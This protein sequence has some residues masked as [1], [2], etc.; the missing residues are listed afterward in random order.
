MKRFY[1]WVLICAPLCLF[2]WSADLSQTEQLIHD[3]KYLEAIEALDTAQNEQ[4]YQSLAIY[5]N[6]GYCYFK[7][8][9]RA[10][11]VL[12]YERALRLS[13]R[14]K[15]LKEVLKTLND[16]LENQIFEIPEFVL[17]RVY[18]SVVTLFNSSVWAFL[19]LFLLGLIVILVAVVLFKFRFRKYLYIISSL[20]LLML[21]T[22]LMS[23]HKKYLESN[24]DY[25][26]VMKNDISLMT[27]ADERSGGIAL[28][29]AGTKVNVIDEIA[30]WYKVMLSD[31]SVG[32]LKKEELEII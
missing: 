18:N 12:N 16:Q 28:L 30:E 17:V 25:A 1:L 8:D 29:S 5:S 6:L 27:A 10:N 13:P 22:S 11:A 32:W 3:G 20:V 19:Q 4:K 31:K 9:D 15:G 14:D 21:V 26:I 2:S 24:R 23:Q 7:I